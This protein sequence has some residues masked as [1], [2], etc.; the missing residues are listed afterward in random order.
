MDLRPRTLLSVGATLACLIVGVYFISSETVVR[1][2]EKLEVADTRHSVTQVAD[3]L[4]FQLQQMH[5]AASD[6][7]D[8]DDTYQFMKDRNKAYIASNLP[9]QPSAFLDLDLFIFLDTEGRIFYSAPFVRPRH[10]PPPLAED[11]RSALGF[12]R[13]AGHRPAPTASFRGIVALPG[14]ETAMVSV[15]PIVKSS[16]KG[17]SRGWIVSVLRLDDLQTKRLAQRAHLA[18]DLFSLRGNGLPQDCANVLGPLLGNSRSV[19]VPLNRNSVAGYSLIDDVYGNPVNMLRIEAPRTIYAEGLASRRFLLGSVMAAGILFGIV[20]LWVIELAALSRVSKLAKIVARIGLT[21]DDDAMVSLPGKDELARLAMGIDDLV[22]RLREGKRELRRQNHKLEQAILQL[23]ETNHTLA[24]AVEGI[25][26]VDDHGRIVD[27]NAAFAEMHG[28]MGVPLN[29]FHWQTLIVSEDHE[30][31]SDANVEMIERGKSRCE[32]RGRRRDGSTFYEEIVLVQA[33]GDGESTVNHWFTRDIS[34]RKELEAQ[35][36]HQA[37]HDT[38]TGLPNRALFMES[39]RVA[40]QK[41]RRRGDAL[42]VLFLDLDD[43]KSINDS[44]GHEA[45]DR[46]LEGVAERIL[47]CVRKHDTVAR[48][49]G[50]EFTVLLSRISKED[51]A[52]DVAQRIVRSLQAPIALPGGKAFAGTSIGIAVSKDG[53]LDA[54]TLLHHAD[55]AMYYSKDRSRPR[56]TVFSPEMTAPSDERRKLAGSLRTAIES[57]GLALAFQPIVL[58]SNGRPTGF[59]AFLRWT[60]PEHGQVSAQTIITVAEEAGL[61]DAI[62]RWCLRRACTDMKELIEAFPQ[63]ASLTMSVN[64]SA[65]QLLHPWII[66]EIEAALMVSELSAENLRIEVSARSLADS[67]KCIERLRKISEI[68]VKLAI[69]DFG[70]G[71]HLISKL[72]EFPVDMVKIDGSVT[73]LLDSADEARAIAQ[74][75]LIMAKSAGVRVVAESIENLPQLR[76]LREMECPEGQGILFSGPVSAAELAANLTKDAA[77]WPYTQR[78]RAA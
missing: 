61:M 3:E 47:S 65:K 67:D 13:P 40:C 37:Y 57:D 22:Q 72:R 55:M 74:A 58:L 56:F 43:F 64:M 11:I 54:E 50:D 5:T 62:G 78:D 12:N 42:A 1:S 32:V 20:T 19:V 9:A 28:Y 68:G 39:L 10:Q 73:W 77:D 23:A 21:E 59:E 70:T 63:F 31:L 6:W 33:V 49:G 48:L 41:A 7:S 26:E 69:D 35:I 30:T 46:L 45:G 71:S 51:D 44:M 66:E 76:R 52:V 36:K 27:F 34:E 75:M 14:G 38:L 2:A 24:N 15:R 53:A 16:G 60:D 8:W 4:D 29:G 17:P 25:T 18:V